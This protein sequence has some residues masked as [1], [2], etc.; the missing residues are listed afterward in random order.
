M[1]HQ[2]VVTMHKISRLPQRP[3]KKEKQSHPRVPRDGTRTKKKCIKAIVGALSLPSL[4]YLFAF[5]C[6]CYDNNLMHSF[7]FSRDRGPGDCTLLQLYLDMGGLPFPF[8]LPSI[9]FARRAR[10]VHI[11]CLSGPIYLFS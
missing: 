5:I 2:K 7:E 11:A 1:A 3:M 9:P 8:P 10:Q 6:I 4:S